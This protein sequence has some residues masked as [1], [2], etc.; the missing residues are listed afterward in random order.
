M[1]T[2]EI[3]DLFFSIVNLC[4]FLKIDAEEAL[5]VTNRKF[6]LRFRKIVNEL[7]KQGKKLG[8]VN[9]AEMDKIWERLKVKNQK[10]K[11]KK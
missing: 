5:R 8:E 1:I 10:L 6:T 7:K 3:G 2:E 4:R 11:G 9:L